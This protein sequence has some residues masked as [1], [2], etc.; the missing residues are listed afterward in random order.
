MDLVGQTI[1]STTNTIGDFDN[2]F[3]KYSA[4]SSLV[5]LAAAVCIGIATKEIIERLM[6]EV[7]LP[8]IKYMSNTS[9]PFLIYT[10]LLK[11]FRN[12]KNV[13]TILKAFG[14]IAWLFIVWSV[15]VFVSFVLF[16]KLLDKNFVS[17]Q[18]AFFHKA[19]NYAVS[20]QEQIKKKI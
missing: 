11:V 7:L 13:T 2:E 19:G 20:L 10:F 14:N 16:K 6:N 8:L 9:I 5:T 15:I 4:N 18:L 12:K 1:S 3:K 17:Q